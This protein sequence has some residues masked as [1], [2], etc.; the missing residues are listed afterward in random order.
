MLLEHYDTDL[1]TA[2]GQGCKGQHRTAERAHCRNR[3]AQRDEAGR[4]WRWQQAGLALVWQSVCRFL[5]RNESEIE[6]GQLKVY[7][8]KP[9]GKAWCCHVEQSTACLSKYDQ[10]RDRTMQHVQHA[11]DGS[12]PT[13]LTA[14][15]PRS[16]PLLLHTPCSTMLVLL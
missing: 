3:S 12:F 15:A 10:D 14:L 13:G 8:L 5:R 7:A 6:C 4:Q 9:Q 2:E 11:R 16:A 1:V